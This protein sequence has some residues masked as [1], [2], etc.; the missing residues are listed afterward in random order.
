MINSRYKISMPEIIKNKKEIHGIPN[1]CGW[2]SV[3]L[4]MAEARSIAADKRDR[5]RRL[6]MA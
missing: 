2:M 1:I 4:K 3:K 6:A 5:V